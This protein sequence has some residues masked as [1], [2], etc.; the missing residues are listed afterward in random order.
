MENRSIEASTSTTIVRPISMSMVIIVRVSG[1]KMPV[2]FAQHRLDRE[3]HCISKNHPCQCSFCSK[4]A[5]T[6]P[7]VTIFILKSLLPL[8]IAKSNFANC[9]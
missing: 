5:L 7:M 4:I 1:I 3:K 6:F 9:V 2:F 8:I